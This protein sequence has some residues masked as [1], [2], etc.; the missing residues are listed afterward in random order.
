MRRFPP[1][2]ESLVVTLAIISRNVASIEDAELLV[3][4]AITPSM[5]D[6]SDAKEVSFIPL[7]V[8]FADITSGA[9]EKSYG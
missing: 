6:L 2:I 1:T 9:S 5:T 7:T 3:I 8:K 4:S